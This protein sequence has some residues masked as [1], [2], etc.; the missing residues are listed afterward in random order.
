M[1]LTSKIAL[2]SLV[3]L[4]FSCGHP[5]PKKHLSFMD[6]LAADSTLTIRQLKMHTILPADYYYNT[7]HYESDT[8]YNAGPKYLA[9]V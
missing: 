1:N 7:S 3:I 8:V 5:T 4:W 6:S 9:A 2:L